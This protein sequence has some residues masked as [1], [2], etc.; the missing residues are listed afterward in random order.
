VSQYEG[1]ASLAEIR[2]ELEAHG[3]ILRRLDRRMRYATYGSILK[4]LVYIG[5][6]LG[7]FV[8]LKPYLE[9]IVGVA[10]KLEGTAGAVSTFRE[11]WATAF[12]DFMNTFKSQR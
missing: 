8:W 9:A 3:K 1:G 12:E 7:T 6:A 11:S 4:W 5:L 2:E 10:H